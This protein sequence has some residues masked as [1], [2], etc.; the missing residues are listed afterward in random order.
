MRV[1]V[2]GSREHTDRQMIDQ[3]L[4][5]VEANLDPKWD[6]TDIVLV[7]GAAPGADTIAAELARD[8]GWQVEAH[9]AD[10]EKYGKRAGYIRNREMADAGADLCLAFPIGE[11]RGTRMMMDLA[12]RAGIR[13]EVW[14][15]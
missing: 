7:H 9:H 10:W 2:T 11:S 4:D 8:K 1:I 12:Q 6:W 3:A 5:A 15:S 14:E 13:L